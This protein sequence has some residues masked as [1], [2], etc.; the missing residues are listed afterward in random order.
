M[1]TPAEN[2]EGYKDSSPLY[3]ADNLGGRVLLIHGTDDDN[4]HMQNTMN[5]VNALVDLGK[6]F[7][8]YI[9]PGQ[10]H[11]FTGQTVT[12]YLYACYLDFFRKYL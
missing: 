6:P 8:L 10:K 11:G 3:A 1:R 12:R 7:E 9:Q 5:F 4:V 2:P